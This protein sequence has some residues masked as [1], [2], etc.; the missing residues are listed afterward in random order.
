MTGFAKKVL[1]ADAL[2]PLSELMFAQSAPSFCDAWI[3]NFAASARIYIDFAAYSDIAIGLGMM[4]G[5]RIPENFRFPYLARSM[6]ELWQRWHISLTGWLIDYL[7]IPL[8]GSRRGVGRTVANIVFTFLICGL[9]HGAS[10]TFV[11]WGG[12][13]GALLCGERWLRARGV[14]DRLPEMLKPLRTLFIWIV[15][16]VFFRA[17]DLEIATGFYRGM[18]GLHGFALSDALAW[19]VTGLQ[20]TTLCAAYLMIFVE[21]FWRSHLRPRLVGSAWLSAGAAFAVFLLAVVRLAARGYEPFLYYQ[22]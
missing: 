6:S 12:L 10:W 2:L 18:I 3:G 4:L 15:I 13:H 17:P 1:L 9:W 16:G 20:L 8:G 14:R 22:F 19:Q 7:Y 21:P 5:F 11:I